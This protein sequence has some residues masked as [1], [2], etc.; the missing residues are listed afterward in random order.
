MN[1]VRKLLEKVYRGVGTSRAKRL[2][3]LLERGE[4]ALLQ[5]ERVSLPSTYSGPTMYR[6]DAIVCDIARKLLLPGDTA[7]RRDA[8]VRTFW[9]SEAECAITNVRWNRYVDNQGPFDPI[10]M[11]VMPFIKAWR[12]ELRRVL[13]RVSYNL[14]PAFSGGSTLSDF[15]KLTTIPDKMSSTPTTYRWFDTHLTFSRTPFDKKDFTQVRANRFFTVP[16]DSSKDRGCCVEAS[17]NVSLQLAVGKR[18]KKKYQKAYQ[19]DLTYAQPLHRELARRSSIDGSYATIDLSNASD[20]VART[21]VKAL[22]PADWYLL[23]NSL[24][25]HSTFIDGKTVHL[26]KFS[27]MGN[28]FTFE[29]ETI[30]FRTM[31]AALGI[32]DCYVYGD[33]IIVPSDRSADVLA[34]LAFAGFTP[35]RG[36]TFCE[37]PFRESCGGDFFEGEPVRAHFLKEIPDEPQKW[38]SLANGLLR[39]DPELLWLR[40]A[41]RF[42]IDQLPNDWRNFG[43]SELGDLV[44]HDRDS[45]PQTH[46]FRRHEYVYDGPEGK[47]RRVTVE[48]VLPA[49]RVKR[50]V[51]R[52]Y[53]LGDRKSVV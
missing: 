48:N 5:E 22:L 15:G 27:S 14:E 19:V 4:W 39:A 30:L 9:S 32:T 17:L 34:C 50:P 2:L 6:K 7:K 24:R 42:C 20:T 16:K 11:R 8:A 18:L 33:D 51:S 40:A 10:D 53:D 43:P 23:L 37:G 49:W 1:Q 12:K 21:L 45:K 26:N 47:P 36:K 31:L 41:W 44:L 38:V 35:N 13:G 3:S 28:G 46:T 52:T 29:L 25:A